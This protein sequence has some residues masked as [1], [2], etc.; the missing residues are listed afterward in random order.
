MSDIFDEVSAELRRDSLQAAWD[1]YGRYLIG[2]AIA[3][4]LVVAV[5][6]GT[7]AAIES[8]N[9]AASQRYNDMLDTL[10]EDEAMP[11]VE[12]L[13]AFAALEDNGYGALA[14]FS[15]AITQAREGA[16]VPALESFGMI[17]DTRGLPDSLR[18][19]AALQ[20]AI[21]LLDSG[22]ELS[23]I[24][25]R[26]VDLLDGDNG[27]QPMARETMALAYMAN[28]KPLEARDLFREQL[29][30]PSVTSLTRERAMIML[31]TVSGA[32]TGAAAK[33][34]ADK[35]AEAPQSAK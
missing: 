14:R 7:R 33:T 10:V 19:L 27:L 8:R 25:S 22:G 6:I 34:Q 13:L 30:D 21:I 24:E 3:L 28:D 2:T 16:H 32:L 11:N 35:P 1:K 5:F 4:V 15:A 12:K 9:E 31:Q 23:A 26:L 17:A 20:A 18:D 29:A